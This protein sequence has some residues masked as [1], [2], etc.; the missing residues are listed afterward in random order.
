[1]TSNQSEEQQKFQSD[2]PLYRKKP[3]KIKIN[4][5]QKKI[6]VF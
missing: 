3:E 5:C 1:M 4:K 6:F 2:K